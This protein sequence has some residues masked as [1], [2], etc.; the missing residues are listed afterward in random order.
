MRSS[1]PLLSGDVFVCE[2]EIVRGVHWAAL[3]A[4]LGD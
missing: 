4:Y 3:V 2:R 1:F